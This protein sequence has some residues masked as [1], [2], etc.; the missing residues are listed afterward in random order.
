MRKLSHRTFLGL[1]VLAFLTAG[2]A[3]ALWLV[4]G[5]RREETL[6]L[7]ASQA[8]EERV[9][10]I[11]A[12]PAANLGRR[13]SVDRLLEAVKTSWLLGGSDAIQEAAAES[14]QELGPV[15]VPELLSR[16]AQA[17]EY[18]TGETIYNALRGLGD[19]AMPQILT[20]L[21]DDWTIHEGVRSMLLREFGPRG[22][23]QLLA[24]VRPG[25]PPDSRL[26]VLGIIARLGTEARPASLRLL[27]LLDDPAELPEIR[28]QALS[29]LGAI[30]PLSDAMIPRLKGLLRGAI[31]PLRMTAI[32]ETGKLGA[33]G[34]PLAQE[35]AS[36]VGS[37]EASWASWQEAAEALAKVDLTEAV[38]LSQAAQA[39]SSEDEETRRFAASCIGRRGKAFRP[40][41]GLAAKALALATVE[42]SASI[43]VA[44]L[45]F[46]AEAVPALL[47]LLEG[48]DE[49]RERIA[50]AI[51]TATEIHP[52]TLRTV[53]DA[54]PGASARCH[55]V[56][57]SIL[58]ARGG[59]ARH[60]LAEAIR[61]GE[62]PLREAAQKAVD[63]LL[64]DP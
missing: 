51:Q 62:A 31:E 4:T 12:L 46:G 17:D 28:S 33:R 45:S 57:M 8:I 61:N 26:R 24:R 41:L 20:A 47:P 53:V 36:I 16:L 5:W 9:A 40:L 54:L 25:G 2:A 34:G 19:R 23:P 56:L 58:K 7:I 39:L 6:R 37:P 11:R 52:S 43:Q 60:Y 38:D 44:V 14:L 27:K 63:E 21:V 3:G 49:A 59:A 50:T 64:K 32:Q 13:E 10:G 48:P 15:I 42:S 18:R 1:A 55:S 35:L 30:E 22:L 29:A